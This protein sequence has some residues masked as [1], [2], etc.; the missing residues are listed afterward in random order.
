[1][2]SPSPLGC[3]LFATLLLLMGS[4]S[5][6]TAEVKLFHP[7]GL[8]SI[9]DALGSQFQK[10]T[11][12]TLVTTV[13][14][15]AVLKS[16]IDAG[17]VFDVAVLSP[18]QIDDLI[19]S[20]KVV[21][22]TRVDLAR[23]G[24]GVGVRAGAPKPD[25]STIEAFRDTLLKSESVVH[26]QGGPSAAHFAKMLAQMGITDEMKSKLRPVRAGLT[27]QPVANGEADLIVVN[28]ASI[29]GSSGVELVGPVPTELQDWITFTI[30]VSSLAAHPEPSRA[31]AQYLTTPS[32][33]AVIKAKGMVPLHK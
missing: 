31:F 29:L 20:G 5:A 22:A 8:R 10:E 14:V 11:G 32:A 12:H 7:S 33:A 28:M 18:T 6:E 15:P 30:G 19:S 4:H 16:R 25:V 23:V 1:M 26:V 2:S 27:A 21:L 17:E 3:K 13:D 24:V 9:V